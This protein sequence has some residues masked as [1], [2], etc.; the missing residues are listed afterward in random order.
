MTDAVLDSGA[1]G[2]IKPQDALKPTVLVVDDEPTVLMY[3]AE[4]LKSAGLY[5]VILAN[6]GARAI[7]MARDFKGE[8]RVLL[9][10]FDMP[11]M[12]GSELAAALIVERPKLKV[13]LMS[14]FTGGTLVLNEGWHFLPKP[15]VASQL[16]A[17]VTTLAEPAKVSRFAN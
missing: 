1:V 9:S 6:T 15:F 16:C 8:I 13:L 4:M 17:L 10:D 5:N 11:G 7:Q 14:G 3:V 12:T 2:P